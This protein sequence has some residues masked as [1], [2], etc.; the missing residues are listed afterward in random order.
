MIAIPLLKHSFWGWFAAIALTV[1]ALATAAMAIVKA[2][3]FANKWG[4]SGM[5]TAVIIVGGLMAAGVAMAWIFRGAF[6]EFYKSIGEQLG[7]KGADAASATVKRTTGTA[8]K[9][10]RPDALPKP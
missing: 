6:K 3:Q 10:F 4:G 9:I 8:G 7:L 5:S 1:V 2:G